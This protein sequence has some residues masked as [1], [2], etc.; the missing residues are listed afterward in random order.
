MRCQLT[1][2]STSC[3]LVCHC[4]QAQPFLASQPG[5]AVD[6]FRLRTTIEQLTQQLLKLD[7][8]EVQGNADIRAA[9]KAQIA[10]IEGLADRLERLKQA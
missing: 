8:V 10:R 7:G 6:Q 1:R 3:S 4:V 9:R 2:H 5:Q